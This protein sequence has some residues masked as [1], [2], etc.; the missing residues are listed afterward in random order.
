MCPHIPQIISAVRVLVKPW[1]FMFNTVLT[2][3]TN[4]GQM[5]YIWIV[6]AC[7]TRDFVA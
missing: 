7:L 4:R 3:P 5:P 6:T 2:E 1:L